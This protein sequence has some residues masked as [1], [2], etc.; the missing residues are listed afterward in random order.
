MSEEIQ[1][2][3]NFLNLNTRVPCLPPMSFTQILG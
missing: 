3:Q 2:L 1:M